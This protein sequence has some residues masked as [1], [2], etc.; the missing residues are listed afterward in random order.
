[1]KNRVFMSSWAKRRHSPLH[2]Y[3]VVLYM[4]GYSFNVCIFYWFAFITDFL[5][6][7]HNRTEVKFIGYIYN[8]KFYHGRFFIIF[9]M[10]TPL[11][12]KL[13]ASITKIE[14]FGIWPTLMFLN[15]VFL[16]NQ[17]SILRFFIAYLSE[18]WYKASH[19]IS[20]VVL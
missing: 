4:I 2:L 9:L 8:I 14:N 7:F 20:K 1:M 13:K 6:V 11:N 16:C 3:Y 18:T 17:F 15:V 19:Q 12:E 5:V 10:K